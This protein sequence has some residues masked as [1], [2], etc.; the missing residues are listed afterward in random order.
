MFSSL[1]S[2]ARSLMKPE[3][4]YAFGGKVNSS[5]SPNFFNH[6]FISNNLEGRWAR[7]SLTP[8]LSAEIFVAAGSKV[9]YTQAVS[10]SF[11]VVCLSPFP[12]CCTT[13]LSDTLLWLL[14]VVFS[15]QAKQGKITI[16]W[17]FPVFHFSLLSLKL[18]WN[19]LLARKRLKATVMLIMANPQTSLLHTFTH[20][21]LWSGTQKLNT[22]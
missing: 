6:S 14:P 15:N 20:Q 3:W 21:I 11:I 1:W 13:A 5:S 9:R 2:R 22:P 18:H 10:S 17:A 12:S 8:S 16:I 7:R 4:E 19:S